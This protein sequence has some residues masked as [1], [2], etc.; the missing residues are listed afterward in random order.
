MMDVVTVPDF[1]GASADK[2]EVRTIIFLANWI[3]NAGNARSFP[4][5]L[6]C[7]GAPPPSVTWMA[8]RATAQI[9]IHEPL[10]EQRPTLNKLRGFGVHRQTKHL[11]LLDTDVW[12]LSDFSNLAALGDTVAAAA[13]GRPR[14]PTA[15]WH[16]IYESSGV[17]TPTER[18][19]STR[20]ELGWAIGVANPYSGQE[21]ELAQMFPYYNTGIIYAP[22][23]CNLEERWIQNAQC[24]KELFSDGDPDYRPQKSVVSCDQAAFALSVEQ[25][26]QE[27]VPFTRLA[28]RFHANRYR[29]YSGSLKLSDVKL[30]HATGFPPKIARPFTSYGQMMVKRMWE[31]WRLR[32]PHRK[33][34]AYMLEFFA[35]HTTI[36]IPMVQQLNSVYKRHFV[37]RYTE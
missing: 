3:E 29:L 26:K 19:C 20:G 28:P 36:T 10:V 7:I 37:N 8:E 16:K 23:S 11:L 31:E 25:L 9:T 33:R 12:V 18:I 4:L 1:S 14:V 32:N 17:P 24:I 34:H 13:S 35:T 30:Y 5:H 21:A 6:A 15:Y 2:H 22:W 27:G